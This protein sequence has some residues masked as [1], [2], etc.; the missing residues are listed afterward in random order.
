[1][2]DL[3]SVR[4]QEAWQWIQVGRR[5]HA[6]NQLTVLLAGDPDNAEAWW[7]LAIASGDDDT[8]RRALRN[9][10]RLQRSGAIICPANPGFYLQPHSIADLVDFVVGRVMDLLGV[11]HSL[12]IRWEG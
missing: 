2:D 1:M 10:L 7:L 4:L 9:M 8:R 5:D 3:S 12:H 6:L 11:A